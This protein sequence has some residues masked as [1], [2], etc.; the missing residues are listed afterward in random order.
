MRYGILIQDHRCYLRS[1]AFERK[2]KL[3]NEFLIF[4]GG[5]CRRSSQRESTLGVR[6][7]LYKQSLLSFLFIPCPDSNMYKITKIYG[8]Y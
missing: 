4:I 8:M 5:V 2:K 1:A 6:Y 3:Q 7:I